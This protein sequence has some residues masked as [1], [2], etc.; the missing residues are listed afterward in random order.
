M[1]PQLILDAQA[2]LGEGPCWDDALNVLWWVDI[3][4]KRLHRFHPETGMNDTI[5]LD[6]QIGTVVPTTSRNVIIALQDG[7][8]ELDLHTYGL[9]KWASNED[10][11][12]DNRFNDGKCDVAGRLWVGTLNMGGEKG[13]GA[14]YR[15]DTNGTMR[16]M[17]LGVSVS[18][19]L[20]WSPDHSKMYWIDSPTK[21]VTEF[22]YDP[23]SGSI[24]NPRPVIQFLDEHG[25]PDGM[26]TDEEGMLWI[27]HWD[28]GQV[29]RWDPRT[30]RML[31]SIPV[32]APRVT[33]CVFGGPDRKTLYITTARIRLSEEMLEKYPYSGGL[34]SV[35]TSVKGLRTFPF[36]GQR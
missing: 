21:Q 13:S 11:R 18:N 5:H 33:S 9:N 36:C 27:A 3:V 32:P 12:T 24:S 15:L 7:I 26:T 22:D 14:L 23:E 34:F 6:Q 17:K 8:Y 29:S 30:G 10:V 16:K 35:Q 1:K 31:E 20:G 28:G 19:G 4:E 2:T 25:I